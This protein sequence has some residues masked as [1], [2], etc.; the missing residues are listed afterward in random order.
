MFEAARPRS[1][2]FALKKVTG[3][4]HK[5]PDAYRIIIGGKIGTA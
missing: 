3:H 2:V 5:S 1:W 4:E